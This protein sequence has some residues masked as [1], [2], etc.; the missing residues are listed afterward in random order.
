M[1]VLSS[2]RGYVGMWLLACLCTF[3]KHFTLCVS[4]LDCLVCRLCPMYIPGA[5]RGQR[6]VSDPLRLGLQK[7]V[8][9]MW[10]SGN[11][12]RSSG[13]TAIVLNYGAISPVPLGASCSIPVVYPSHTQSSSGHI[14]EYTSRTEV[15]QT[16][17][18]QR[19]AL[20]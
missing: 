12:P 20:S 5:L 19:R 2:Y 17:G 16:P 18:P 4:Y 1:S 6:R 11:K 10:V 8:T 15:T 7:V 3:L 13:R 9:I 14:L